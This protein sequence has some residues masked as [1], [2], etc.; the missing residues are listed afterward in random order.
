[1][2][3]PPSCS[4]V[5]SRFRSGGG[6]AG[7]RG[8]GLSVAAPTCQREADEAEAHHAELRN[9]SAARGGSGGCAAGHREVV[10]PPVVVLPAGCGIWC[11]CLSSVEDAGVE[12][13][14]KAQAGRQ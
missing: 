12:T 10:V 9:A 4:R 5:S 13:R 8:S 7:Q 1:V 6:G 3:L 11:L 2:I 14:Q